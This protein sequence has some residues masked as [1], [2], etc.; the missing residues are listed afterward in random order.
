MTAVEQLVEQL[1][2]AHSTGYARAQAKLCKENARQRALVGVPSS[3]PVVAGVQLRQLSGIP[4]TEQQKV[5]FR[6]MDRHSKGLQAV[7]QQILDRVQQD[8]GDGGSVV[9]ALLDSGDF[10]EVHMIA[11]RAKG[12][13]LAFSGS[14]IRWFEPDVRGYL[15]GKPFVTEAVGRRWTDML[16]KE[17]HQPGSTGANPAQDQKPSE[18]DKIARDG[19]RRRAMN[20]RATVSQELANSWMH[21]EA[22]AAQVAG[23]TL[24]RDHGISRC[25]ADLNCT[26]DVARIAY[27]MLP[28]ALKRPRGKPGKQP[29]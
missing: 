9:K 18:S 11:W 12:A 22:T 20:M 27:V 8:L 10:L 19:P 2:V 28:E 16:H 25:Q 5:F 4:L 15:E 17:M 13:D 29:A 6:E 21:K 7:R 24:G 26:R 14:A 1:G 3:P 23:E